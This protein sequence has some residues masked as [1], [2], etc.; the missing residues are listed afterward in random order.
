MEGDEGFRW[1]SCVGQ[2]G[3]LYKWLILGEVEKHWSVDSWCYLLNAHVPQNL[4]G[5]PNP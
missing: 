4:Q 2:R 5:K 1:K 3:S